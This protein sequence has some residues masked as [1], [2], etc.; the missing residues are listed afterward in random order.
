ML[1]S[2]TQRFFYLTGDPRYFTI[3]RIS[4]PF[5]LF[6][7]KNVVHLSVYFQTT[8]RRYGDGGTYEGA[9]LQLFKLMSTSTTD[10]SILFITLPIWFKARRR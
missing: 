5:I 3:N 2:G 4:N 8:R 10:C 9:P 1:R 7:Q 6:P